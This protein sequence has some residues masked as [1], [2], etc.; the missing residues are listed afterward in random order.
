MDEDGNEP[1]LMEVD[2]G[3]YPL[4]N[5]TNYDLH[6]DLK[7]TEKPI[8]V[9][10]AKK[11]KVLAAEDQPVLKKIHRGDDVKEMFFFYV[12]EKG[13]T[14]GKAAK[15]MNIPVK[16]GYNWLQKD[17]KHLI[18][19][20]EKREDEEDSQIT[21]NRGRKKLLAAEHKKHLEESFGDNPSTTVDQALE[22]LIE[23]FE[24]LKVGRQTVR[25]FMEDE[26]ALSFKKAYFYPTERNSPEK[27][28]QR[29]E[30]ALNYSE[31][32]LDFQ[33]NCVF[34]DEAAFHVNLKRT[35]AWS[36]KGER[37]IVVTPTTR[38]QTTTILGAISPQG[39]IN[40][41]LRRP[42][43]ASSKKRKL[44]NEA[45]KASGSTAKKITGTVTGH[46]FNFIAS[47]LDVL[48]KHEQFKG[49]YLVMDNIPIHKNV[50][51]ERYIVNRGY[52]CVYLPPYSPEL[53]PIEQFWSV[54]KS[55]LKREKLLEK[56]TF[57][58]RITEA[59]NSVLLSNLQGFF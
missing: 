48:D 45:T 32:D 50:A 43:Q 57:T 55:K 58:S 47:T 49:F 11:S 17:Q 20:L 1:I 16:T 19:R 34:I 21:E 18:S 12:Y 24:G 52:G 22:S 15:L 54:V 41:K 28:Q 33:S 44:Q 38:A 5:V 39:V 3:T 31:T 51:I 59:C 6:M 13:L 53:N 46:Y 29:Y 23:N 35:M 37:A 56:E 14:A 9:K 10:P 27:I 2:E 4:D 25:N 42:F 26:C 36:K 40:V 8:K 7:P 30:W